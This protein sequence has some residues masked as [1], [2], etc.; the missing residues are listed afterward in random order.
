MTQRPGAHTGCWA[1]FPLKDTMNWRLHSIQ[2]S[3]LKEFR[4]KEKVW[5]HFQDL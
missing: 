1:K 3:L 5:T 2:L 4:E